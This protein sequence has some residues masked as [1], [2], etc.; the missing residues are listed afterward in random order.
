MNN[1]PKTAG[2][3]DR[4]RAE[5]VQVGIYLCEV[6]VVIKMKVQI[7]QVR[8]IAVQMILVQSCSKLHLARRGNA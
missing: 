5:V 6:G 1:R 8:I 2:L 4:G 7:G 3:V